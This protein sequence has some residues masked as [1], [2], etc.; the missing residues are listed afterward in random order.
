[1]PP[2]PLP[3]QAAGLSKVF[4]DGPDAVYALDDVTFGC[5]GGSFTAIWGRPGAGK[6]TLLRCLAGLEVPTSGSVLVDPDVV[7]ADE[8]ADVAGL[9]ARVD[10][11]GVTVVIA[12]DDPLA[13]I[14]TD[15]VLFLA[16][17]LLVDA[18]TAPTLEA[19]TERIR[20]LER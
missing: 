12:T 18:L 4:G 14:Q 9:R 11:T 20:L 19:V 17:G 10:A 15:M 3:V 7:F 16:R 5:H 1:V 6:T 2:S 8:P 13:A